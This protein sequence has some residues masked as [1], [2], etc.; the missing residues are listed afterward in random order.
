MTT[1]QKRWPS[2]RQ[3][4]TPATTRCL[5]QTAN[6]N[7]SG[8]RRGRLPR[9]I[10]ATSRL[11]DPPHPITGVAVSGQNRYNSSRPLNQS[12]SQRSSMWQ[13]R[14]E[15]SSCRPKCGHGRQRNIDTVQ[16][17]YLDSKKAIWPLMALK[18]L[19][20]WQPAQ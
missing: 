11:P 4:H 12:S 13:A 3:P 18:Y 2:Q 14:I 8:A 6:V 7:L 15:C 20:A 19:V 10:Q 1:I 9:N 5:F 16:T 17:I